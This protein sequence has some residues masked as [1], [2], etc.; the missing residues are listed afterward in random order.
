[1]LINGTEYE[2]RPL[3]PEAERA[4]TAYVTKLAKAIDK[5]VK[6]FIEKHCDGLDAQCRQMLLNAWIN[7]P[8]WDAPGDE[9]IKACRESLPAAWAL[10]HYCLSPEV[11]WDEAKQL[12]TQANK[13]ELWAAIQGATNPSDDEIRARNKVLRER[14]EA[15]R[16]AAEQAADHGG[17]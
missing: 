7:S 6:R 8:G 16:K 2:V 9:A 12:I 4:W 14:I 11:S 13:G 3:S 1:M 5:P 10:A 15:Q 17:E